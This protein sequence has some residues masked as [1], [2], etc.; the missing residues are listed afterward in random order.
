LNKE[1]HLRGVVI[2]CAFSSEGCAVNFFFG[3]ARKTILC[4]NEKK[5]W[6]M[7]RIEVW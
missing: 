2:F 4:W 7:E 3:E 6:Y 1:G 5:S